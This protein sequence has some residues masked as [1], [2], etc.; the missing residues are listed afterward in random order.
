MTLVLVLVLL[1]NA[2]GSFL[3]T[4]LADRTP[5]QIARIVAVCWTAGG[6]LSLGGI[7]WIGIQVLGTGQEEGFL[8]S[9]AVYLRLVP[10]LV[11]ALLLGL[12]F[13]LLVRLYTGALAGHG[14]RLGRVWWANTLGAAAGTV[15]G[16]WWLM[17]TVGT[18]RGLVVCAVLALGLAVVALVYAQAR[19]RDFLPTAAG[20]GA[21]A[22]VALMV[23]LGP[24]QAYRAVYGDNA[25][26]ATWEG[27]E[28][29]TVVWEANEFSQILTT[30][31]RSI[32]ARQSLVAGGR[33]SL[34]IAPNAKR[35][36]IVGFGTGLFAKGLLA[37][38]RLE[39]LV[40][41][42]IDGAQFEAAEHFEVGDLL[43]DPRVKLVVDDAV[44][45]LSTSDQSFDLVMIDA[46]GPDAS[47]AV[48][49]ADFNT[50]VSEH[51]SKDGVLWSKVNPLVPEAMSAV[52]DSFRCVFPYAYLFDNGKDTSAL[53]GV[54]RE[55]LKYHPFRLTPADSACDPLT[56]EHPRRLRTDYARRLKLPP[57]G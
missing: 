52:K 21:T 38:P 28:A 44:H 17:P 32:T 12:G 7:E 8:S 40:I 15:G 46:W 47:P 6:I 34:D 39:E 30:N 50:L 33:D 10:S 16:G 14:E 53:M 20:A 36:L 2:V 11:P 48:Y 22:L 31:G 1:G 37:L 45:Y 41:V 3:A 54:P 27:W 5:A 35:V 19:V 49:T 13:P 9:N 24:G 56:H 57:P 55:Y 25:I 23:P 51:L 43:T 26:I 42:E 4:R 18:D 29:T